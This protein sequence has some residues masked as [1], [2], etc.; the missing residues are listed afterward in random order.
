MSL[1]LKARAT[2]P[3]LKGRGAGSA[4]TAQSGDSRAQM[5]LRRVPELLDERM[6]L[7]CLLDDAAL[8]AL[9]TAVN[10]A[11]LAKPCLVRDGEVFGD[12]RGDVPGGE[13]MQIQRALDR[14]LVGHG[15]QA[16]V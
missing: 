12:N 13:R 3:G 15:G 14:D 11:D 4:S 1:A 5:G 7:D 16:A 6:S 2:A 9:A 10:Q 8:D